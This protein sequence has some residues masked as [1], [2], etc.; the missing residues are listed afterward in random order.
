MV[1]ELPTE[2]SFTNSRFA[3][4]N[5]IFPIRFEFSIE[6]INERF[7]VCISFDH[8]SFLSR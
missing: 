5:Q 4:H 3:N 8:Q 7:I 1:N 6:I 2:V